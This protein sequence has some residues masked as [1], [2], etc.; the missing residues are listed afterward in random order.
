M[1]VILVK[2]VRKLGKVGETVT[3]ANGHGRNFLM[4][5]G[6]AIRATKENTEKFAAIAKDL[7]AK[8]TESKKNA[9]AAVKTIKGK[10]I[11]FIT[12]SAADGRL[13]GSVTAKTLATEISKL[14]KTPLT[15]SNILLDTPIK[16]NGVYEVQVVLHP[17][18][19]TSVLVVVAKTEPEAQDAL[20]EYKEGGPKKAETAKEADLNILEKQA[21]TEETATVESEIQEASESA[22]DSE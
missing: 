21:K 17:E 2:S 12:Q 19:I 3:V 11:D 22:Q 16:S 14:A 4:P 18:V 5:Q 8:N 20:R 9:E 6:Y 15:Y 13:Y 7:E 1:Q 10:H